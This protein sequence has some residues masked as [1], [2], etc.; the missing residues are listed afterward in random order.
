MNVISPFRHKNST[1]LSIYILEIKTKFG[2]DYIVK[3]EIIKKC[4]KYKASDKYCLL[5]I[6]EKLSIIL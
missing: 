6:E 2:I 1:K 3:W 4:R 5:W